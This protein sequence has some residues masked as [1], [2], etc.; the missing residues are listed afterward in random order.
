MHRQYEYIFNNEKI[1]VH[2]MLFKSLNTSKS[3]VRQH[4][5][6]SSSSSTAGLDIQSS[7]QEQQSCL[8]TT[9]ANVKHTFTVVFKHNN[10]TVQNL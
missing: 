5:T 1:I 4:Q 6:P 7:L 3:V 9:D 10:V 2:I 8:F